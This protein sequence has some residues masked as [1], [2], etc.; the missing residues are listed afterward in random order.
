MTALSITTYSRLTHAGKKYGIGGH[1]VVEQREAQTLMVTQL[2]RLH[3]I[4]ICNDTNELY[5]HM[6]FYGEMQRGDTG[7][8]PSIQL[9][10]FDLKR[11]VHGLAL[12]E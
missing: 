8:L 11:V 5:F 3:N 2:A 10:A 4:S 9:G 1:Y 12:K 7:A 6:Q